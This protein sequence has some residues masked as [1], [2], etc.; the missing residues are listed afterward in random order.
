MIISFDSMCFFER[1]LVGSKG[2]LTK[3]IAT[4]YE[5]SNEEHPCTA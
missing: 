1:N 2:T 3:T 5:K 4:S